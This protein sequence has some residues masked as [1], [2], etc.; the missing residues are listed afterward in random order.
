MWHSNLLKRCKDLFSYYQVIK[1]SISQIKAVMK[2][3]ARFFSPIFISLEL[4]V[5]A[6]RSSAP[7]IDASDSQPGEILHPVG[8]AGGSEPE[9]ED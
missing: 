2:R 6:E 1:W 3:A 7:F 8:P 4:P 9:R 5:E